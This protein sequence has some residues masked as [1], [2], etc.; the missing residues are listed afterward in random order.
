ML[1]GP[2]PRQGNTCIHLGSSRT[3]SGLAELVCNSFAAAVEISW[4]C[5][6]RFVVSW[7]KAGIAVAAARVRVK[8]HRWNAFR[9]GTIKET[10]LRAGFTMMALG[11]AFGVGNQALK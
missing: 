1:A 10:G 11:R 6:S 3:S 5:A 9:V 2:M 8:R 4:I 7:H